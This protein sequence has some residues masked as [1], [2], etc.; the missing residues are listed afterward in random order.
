MGLTY[1]KKKRR[2]R[3]HREQPEEKRNISTYLR[4][5]SKEKSSVSFCL[6]PILNATENFNFSLQLW[7]NVIASM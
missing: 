6:Q 5:F 7:Y 1:V 2:E 4:N 3:R